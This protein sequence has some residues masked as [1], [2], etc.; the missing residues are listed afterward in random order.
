MALVIH[1]YAAGELH[2]VTKS[3]I[4]PQCFLNAFTEDNLTEFKRR[5]AKN[6]INVDNKPAVVVRS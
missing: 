1:A 3:S 6:D 4:T 2:K 5:Y